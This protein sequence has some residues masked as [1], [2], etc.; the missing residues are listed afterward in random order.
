MLDEEFPGYPVGHP[1]L[2]VIRDNQRDVYWSRPE[3]NP[4]PLAVLKVFV[5]PPRVIGEGF[6]PVLP[7][8]VSNSERLLFPLCAT[9]A[10]QHPVGTVNENYSCPHRLDLERGWVGS[11]TSVELNAA[12]KEGYKVTKLIRVLEYKEADKELFRSYMREFL[13]EK[14]HSSG[15]DERI[16]GN[17][18]AEQRFIGECLTRFGMQIDSRRMKTNKGRRQLAKL[19]VNNLWGRFALRNHGLAQCYITDDPAVLAEFLDRSDIDV[20]SL[21]VLSP[22]TIMIGYMKRKDFLSGEEHSCSN[23]I[24]SAW[25][26][27]CARVL[28]L[29]A[30]QKVTRSDG[31]KLLYTD[32]DS[33]IF[34]HPEG[35]NPLEPELGPHIG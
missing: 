23:V 1:T 9:C 11:Y 8:K 21:D 30:M 16:Q 3:D 24:I 19:M 17:E 2:H 14:I 26:T 27:S 33:L 29:K 32:T 5:V 13:A 28:L 20:M 22:T 12:L 34:V 18:E 15:F 4:Y 35:A 6:V 31:C 7:M 10:K 25:T